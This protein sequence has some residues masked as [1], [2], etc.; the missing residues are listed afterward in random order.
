[1]NDVVTATGPPP[2]EQ[3]VLGAIEPATY[4]VPALA[5]LLNC[6]ERHVWRQ[7]DMGRIPGVIRCGRLVRLSRRMIDDWLTGSGSAGTRE[8]RRPRP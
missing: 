5:R 2:S 1:M 4:T 3:P 7:L 6:S 8:L